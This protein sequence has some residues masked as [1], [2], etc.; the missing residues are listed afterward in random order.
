MK[1]T[2]MECLWLNVKSATFAHA[3]DKDQAVKDLSHTSCAPNCENC[4]SFRNSYDKKPAVPINGSCNDILH[5][6]PIDRNRWWQYN[7]YYHLWKQVTSD[8]EW[9]N[10]YKKTDEQIC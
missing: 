2:L 4:N 9:E 10:L 7:T 3:F 5:I 6:C 1:K 8:Q